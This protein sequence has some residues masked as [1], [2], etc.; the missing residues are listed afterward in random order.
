MSMS[1]NDVLFFKERA[2]QKSLNLLTYAFWRTY[3][4]L[5]NE[6]DKRLDEVGHCWPRNWLLPIARSNAT[7]ANERKNDQRNT[8]VE[9]IS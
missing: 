4:K 9:Y 1:A 5:P 3:Y 7:L 6:Y 8:D 2:G